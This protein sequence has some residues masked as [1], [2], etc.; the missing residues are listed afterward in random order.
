MN[1]AASGGAL[2]QQAWFDVQLKQQFAIRVGKFKTLLTRL[3]D[4]IG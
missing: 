3:S 1:A 4:D 2:L